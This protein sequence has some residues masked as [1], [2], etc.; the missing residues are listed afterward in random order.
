[1]NEGFFNIFQGSWIRSGYTKQENDVVGAVEKWAILHFAPLTVSI[2]RSVSAS[3][4]AHWYIVTLSDGV[5][6]HFKAGWIVG[7]TT[8][9]LSFAIARKAEKATRL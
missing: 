3:T 8:L 2:Q 7:A 9:S 1:M 4:S 5:Q 6:N